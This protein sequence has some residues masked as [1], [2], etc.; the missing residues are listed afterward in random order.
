MLKAVKKPGSYIRIDL[1]Y[2]G[3]ESVD[4]IN[5]VQGR[6]KWWAVV[7]TVMNNWFP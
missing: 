1:R 7:N 5:L 3:W 6:N 4:W 2:T